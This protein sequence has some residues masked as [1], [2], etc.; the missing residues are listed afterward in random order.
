MKIKIEINGDLNKLSGIKN[1][2]IIIE[3]AL[4]FYVTIETRKN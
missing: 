3:K 1:E 2:S 4:Q